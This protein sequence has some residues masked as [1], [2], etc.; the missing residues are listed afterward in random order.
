MS[1]KKE[2]GILFGMPPFTFRRE[3][4]KSVADFLKKFKCCLCGKDSHD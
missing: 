4:K 1:K 2:G 3:I